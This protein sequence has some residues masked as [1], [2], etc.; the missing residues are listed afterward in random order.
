M[1][2][3]IPRY[4]FFKFLHKKRSFGTGS[5][6]THVTLQ[7][8]KKL[9]KFINACLAEQLS[10]F[11]NTRVIFLCPPLFLLLG[12]L[13]LHA[14]KLIHLKRSVVQSDTLLFENNRPW[15]AYLDC[16]CRY[17]H[18]RRGYDN[19][20]QRTHNIHQPLCHTV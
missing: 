2:Y 15:T 20:R 13:H 18:N 17:Q 6:K 14:P 16:D 10:D 3:H 1:L 12:R 19:T 5:Y 7:Y 8:V 11:R 9:R 4:F